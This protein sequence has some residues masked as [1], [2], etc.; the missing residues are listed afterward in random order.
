MYTELNEVF[1]YFYC[2][3]A[4]ISETENVLKLP[5]LLDL[6]VL[7]IPARGVVAGHT[8]GL[9][10]C[11]VCSGRSYSGTLYLPGV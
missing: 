10:T 11:Q 4:G 5:C 1:Q 7:R 8:Q 9:Y 3:L 2:K 6:A